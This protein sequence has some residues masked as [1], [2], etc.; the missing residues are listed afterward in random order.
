MCQIT[1]R[2]PLRV[3]IVAI[4]AGCLVLGLGCGKEAK[5]SGEA[6]EAPPS[7]PQ[8]PGGEPGP[9][10]P[11][12][13]GL[14][15]AKFRLKTSQLFD[16]FNKDSEATIKKYAGSVVELDAVVREASR[17]SSGLQTVVQVMPAGA[18]LRGSPTGLSTWWCYIEDPALAPRLIPTQRLRLKGYFEPTNQLH[19]LT[20]CEVLEL[21]KDDA[22]RISAK[23]LASATTANHNATRDKYSYKAIVLI[24]VIKGKYQNAGGPEYIELEGDGTTRIIGFPDSQHADDVKNPNIGAKVTWAGWMRKNYDDAPFEMWRYR[25]VIDEKR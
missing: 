10:Q 3:S 14:G 6:R 9:K 15:E 7:Q 4:F 12:A 11:K 16:E 24:G 20:R 23:E 21:G 22:I 13:S 17:S 18:D 2:M 19:P 1:H 25:H 5:P 8:P